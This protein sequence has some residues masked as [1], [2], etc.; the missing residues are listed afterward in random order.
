MSKAREDSLSPDL[1]HGAKAIGEFL[2]L[3]ERQV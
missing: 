3:T 1:L 2:G